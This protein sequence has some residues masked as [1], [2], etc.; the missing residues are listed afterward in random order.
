MRADGRT[1]RQTDTRKLVFAFR[2]FANPPKNAYKILV[3]NPEW[4]RLCGRFKSMGEDNIKLDLKEIQR[5]C[6]WTVFKRPRTG[7]SGGLFQ[8]AV[9]S[10]EFLG[11]RRTY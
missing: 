7:T 11:G 4:K 5:D 9:N 6:V 10:K 8:T 3:G 2:N 1:D